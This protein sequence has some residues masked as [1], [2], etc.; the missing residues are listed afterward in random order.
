[1]RT[2]RSLLYGGLPD[3]DPLPWTETSLDRDPPGQRPPLDKDSPGHRPPGQRPPVMRPVMHA[4]IET[5]CEQ[6]DT[7]V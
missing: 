5:P 1:M 3:R 7:Q 2:A 4:R 6:N